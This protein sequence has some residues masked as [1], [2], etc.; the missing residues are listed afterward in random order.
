[1]IQSIYYRQ[2]RSVLQRVSVFLHCMSGRTR[3]GW[4]GLNHRLI[5]VDGSPT[6]HVSHSNLDQAIPRNIPAVCLVSAV[7]LHGQIEVFQ[8]YLGEDIELPVRF[9]VHPP[10]DVDPLLLQ[11]PG[12]LHKDTLTK[13]KWT[14]GQFRGDLTA[15]CLLFRA[16]H[17]WR[18][19]ALEQSSILKA[20][21]REDNQHVERTK[22]AQYSG[23]MW[24]LVDSSERLRGRT[25]SHLGPSDLV[26]QQGVE[27]IVP[28]SCWLSQCC[29][30]VFQHLLKLIPQCD[31]LHVSAKTEVSVLQYILTCSL[32]Q[33]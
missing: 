30:I 20:W 33:D 3:H 10:H 2:K 18:N 1:M 32:S 19:L 4:A 17:Q 29:N 5:F 24:V 26:F 16:Y 13:Q 31:S 23:N 12:E 14:L 6:H 8:K 28:L 11:S 22:S 15:T 25:A 27:C 21:K 7:P 9:H